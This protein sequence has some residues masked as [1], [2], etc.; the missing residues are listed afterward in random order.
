MFG[1]NRQMFQSFVDWNEQRKELDWNEEEQER[2]ED[3]IYMCYLYL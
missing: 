3:W 1:T 2:Q